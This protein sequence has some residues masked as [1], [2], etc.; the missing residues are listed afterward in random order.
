[1]TPELHF[2][3]GTASTLK[4]S[5][6]RP[7]LATD[8]ALVKAGLLY[9]DRV[10]LV[11]IGSA[12]G[13][14]L[15]T[16]SDAPRDEKLRWL[17]SFFKSQLYLWPREARGGLDMLERYRRLLQ[18]Q[19]ATRLRAPEHRELLHIR[20]ALTGVWDR[21]EGEMSGFAMRAGAE[22]IVEARDSGLLELHQFSPG[23]LE[24]MSELTPQDT[25]RKKALFDE[26]TLEFFDL[27]AEATANGSTH[28]LFD[29]LSAG[30]IRETSNLGVIA[31]SQSSVARGRHSG[32]ASDLLGRLPLFEDATVGQVLDIR[33]ELEKPLV[34]FRGAVLG[35][36]E[37][38][39]SSAW[40]PDFAGDA[41]A[42]FR[43][44]VEPAV[45]DLEEEVRSNGELAELA[46][47]AFRPED[48]G[49]GL[50][51]M[52][53]GLSQ[54][55]AVA[56]VTLGGGITAATTGVKAYKEWKEDRKNIERSQ[57]YFYYRS[58]ERLRGV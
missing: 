22:A 44:Q 43:K 14:R 32:L 37:E 27:I 41:D 34:R 8:L 29:E 6:E 30:F 51:V 20:N 18:E 28:P 21:Y 24:A 48:V 15:L 12:M 31:P 36:S 55:P 3:I 33:R 26:I 23:M 2:T 42:V 4:D 40:A 19:G 58:R 53:S 56:A 25:A 10:R 7:D 35:F 57:M 1:M 39:C 54:L 47:R 50:L 9:A 13:A 17:E 11:S 46:V 45:L 5:A 52:L 49:T 38:V 16:L